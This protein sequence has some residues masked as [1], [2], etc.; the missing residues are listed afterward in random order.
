MTEFF[1]WIGAPVEID[2][3]VNLLA[4]LLGVRDHP[5]ESLDDEA[6]RYFAARLA[7][8]TVNTD[9]RLDLQATLAGLWEAVKRLPPNQRDTFCFSVTDQ[10]GEDLFSLLIEAEI[11]T[12]PEIARELHRPLDHLFRLWSEMPMDRTA[13]AYELN[14]TRQRVSKWRFRAAERLEKEILPAHPEK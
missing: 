2:A 3:L 12:L 6:K 8:T 14:A 10:N 13:I 9:A 1:P 11:A 4:K 7:E 5:P